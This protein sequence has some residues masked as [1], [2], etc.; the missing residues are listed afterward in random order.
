MQV[1]EASG[2]VHANQRTWLKVL[3][4]TQLV[5]VPAFF[6]GLVISPPADLGIEA[7]RC[8]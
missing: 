3:V 8:R 5:A 7:D 1:V 4:V 6:W 2:R